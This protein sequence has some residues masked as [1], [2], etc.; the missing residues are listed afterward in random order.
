[1]I[2]LGTIALCTAI[3]QHR[4]TMRD[5]AAITSEKVHWTLAQLTAVAVIVLGALAALS[6][7]VRIGPF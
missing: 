1:M 6:V 4:T 3:W 5:I 7:A 2:L